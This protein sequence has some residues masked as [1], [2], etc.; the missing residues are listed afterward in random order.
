MSVGSAGASRPD[1]ASSDVRLSE[2]LEQLLSGMQVD[3][4]VDVKHTALKPDS[5]CKGVDNFISWWNKCLNTHGDS[6]SSLGATV[7]DEPWPLTIACN[8]KKFLNS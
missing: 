7:H 3:T 8:H 4:D 2:L 1:L 5:Y 6:S